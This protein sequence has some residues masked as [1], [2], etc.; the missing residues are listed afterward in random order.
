LHL[1][2]YFPKHEVILMMKSKAQTQMR[3]WFTW[4]FG[5]FSVSVMLA[6]INV[7]LATGLNYYSYLSLFNSLVAG[8]LLAL[9]ASIS[10]SIAGL[11]RE[12]Y[13]RFRYLVLMSVNVLV[14]LWILL[15]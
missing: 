5:C 11:I 10:F 3:S 14:F 1:E 4:A 7:V 15:D 8:I 9:L 6:V 13:R 12:R 2:K